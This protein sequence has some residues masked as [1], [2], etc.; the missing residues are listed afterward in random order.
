[1]KSLFLS[2]ATASLVLAP[3]AMAKGKAGQSAKPSATLLKQALASV[4]AT[5]QSGPP[6]KTSDGD[7]GDD[8]ANPN[9]ILKVCNKDTPAARRAAICPVSGSPN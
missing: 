9:A 6:A 5:A 1:M 4:A 8:H 2:I 3:A 7:Q